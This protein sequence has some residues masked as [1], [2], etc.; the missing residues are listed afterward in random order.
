MLKTE[1]EIQNHISDN[2]DILTDR[3]GKDLCCKLTPRLQLIADKVLP[4]ARVADIGTDHAYIP[5]YLI[6]KGIS[7]YVIASDVKK[8][9]VEKAKD[10]VKKYNLMHRIDV[11]LGNGLEKVSL[12][13]VDTVI[14][15]GMGGVLIAEI[16]SAA[17]SALKT[18]DRLILQPMV[19]QEEVRKWL[20]NNHFKIV[21]EELVMEG[22]KIYNVIVAEHG[23]DKIEKE[24]FN[25]IGKKLVEKKDPLLK[26]LLIDRITELNKIIIQLENKDSRNAYLRLKEC[27]ARLM[28]YKCLQQSI[29]EGECNK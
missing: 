5:I 9:P 4:G 23:E 7:N 26:N 8:G 14:I 27:R 15:A 24:I 25:Y 28:E 11:R 22:S 6:T 19:G 20:I 2:D 1:R 21:D 18:I 17:K 16:L 3:K 13:E 12:G 10:N 29:M